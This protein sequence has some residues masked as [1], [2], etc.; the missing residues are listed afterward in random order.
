VETNAK[1]SA[2]PEQHTALSPAEL[3]QSYGSGLVG[4]YEDPSAT[5]E[6]KNA[7][8]RQTG[9]GSISEA[10][11]ANDWAGSGEGK[12][13]IP[14][15][16]VESMYPGCFPGDAQT[17]GSCVSHS[18][19]NAL[20]ISLCCDVASGL[21]D[22]ITG[23]LERVPEVPPEGIKSG[24]LSAA[25]IYWA[26]GFNSHG[27]SC[28]TAANVAV[29]SVGCVPM[30]NY[31]ALGVDLT[32]INKQIECLYG[33]KKPP[34]EWQT[35]F[36]K[37]RAHSA[38]T[39]DTANEIRD[40]LANGYGLSTCGGEGYSSTR[41]EN[42]VSRRQGSWAHAMACIGCDDRA[43]T[44]AKYGEPLFLILNS[45]GS[46]NSGGRRIMGTEFDIPVGSFWAK[47]G[48]VKRREFIAF[49]GVNGWPAKAIDN[50]LI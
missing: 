40:L 9:F 23:K 17:V 12:L 46:W 50:L 47:W 16:I 6:L 1:F 30:Q 33:S 42:G 39:A 25:P 5:A 36:A 3:E 10:A 41:D 31:E 13:S 29:K 24:V 2:W 48:D 26:R 28:S 27:W 14:F 11:E 20:L 32:N 4:A 49:S 22:P 35:E 7:F 38:V 44:V 18:T 37:Y 15:R 43:E 45:W 21:P 8:V 34:A 19:K